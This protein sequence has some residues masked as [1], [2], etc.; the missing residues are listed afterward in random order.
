MPPPQLKVRAEP[1][2]EITPPPAAQPPPCIGET[3]HPS[4]RGRGRRPGC[5]RGGAGQE[6]PPSARPCGRPPAEGKRSRCQTTCS[7]EGEEGGGGS[8]TSPPCCWGG[9]RPN[10]RRRPGAGGRQGEGSAGAR[11]RPRA[12]DPR[13]VAA[14]NLKV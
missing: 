5:R 10:V 4:R 9:G 2:I 14:R 3:G 13:A 12:S 6:P 11:K 8:F 1:S 7:A